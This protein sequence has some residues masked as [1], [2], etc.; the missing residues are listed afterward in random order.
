M[1][2]SFRV[3]QPQLARQAAVPVATTSSSDVFLRPGTFN[4]KVNEP[5]DR[6]LDRGR[7]NRVVS[8]GSCGAGAADVAAGEVGVER[9]AEALGLLSSPRIRH[10]HEL[11][12]RFTR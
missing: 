4:N 2:V 10:I 8:K 12:S 6:V 1:A 5:N 3:G 7:D 11:S 9:E